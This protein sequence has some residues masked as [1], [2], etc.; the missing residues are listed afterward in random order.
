[1]FGKKV[2]VTVHGLDWKRE[3]WGTVASSVL[4]VGARAAIAFPQVTVVVSQTL[5]AHYKKHYGRDVTY[6]PNG[7]NLPALRA[8]KA[9]GDKLGF[10][11][12]GYILFLSRLVPEKGCHTLIEAFRKL[13]TDKRLVIV[14]SPSH[15][16]DYARSLRELADG[17]SRIV[18][19]G[20]LYENDKD[21]AY[22]NA[23]FFVLPSTIE[24]MALVLLE[25]MAYGKCCLCS[26]IDEN[27]EVIEDKFGLSF[28]TGDASDLQRK[29]ELLLG[30][31]ATVKTL[32][33]EAHRH[34][35]DEYDWS[36]IAQSYLA[37]YRD[38]LQ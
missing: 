6:I 9:A 33:E 32:G 15:S 5:K 24:G 34:V 20:P 14:G 10:T 27:I 35:A 11:K 37:A 29:M 17:D 8:N 13:D 16:D 38:L 30:N 4:K 2:V 12:D 28:A 1:L 18:F 36:R 3:K 21:A 31:P 7:V 22:R 26:D 23:Y 25:A 19:T